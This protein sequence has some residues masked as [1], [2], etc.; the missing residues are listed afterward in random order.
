M[1]ILLWL[2]QR[3]SNPKLRLSVKEMKDV[4]NVIS[5]MRGRITRERI[6]L[7]P[8]FKV[9]HLSGVDF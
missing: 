9:K 7:K 1:Y 6:T 4:E 8:A 3:A 2:N 5:D